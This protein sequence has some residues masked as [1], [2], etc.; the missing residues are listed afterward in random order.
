VLEHPAREVPGD[1]FHH[2]VRLASLTDQPS[3]RL[4]LLQTAR[5]M[6]DA[7][8]AAVTPN[9]VALRESLE[10]RIK[11]ELDVERR[12]ANLSRR[13]VLASSREASRARVAGVQTVLA[14]IDNEDLKLGRR[15]PDVVAALRASVNADLDAA[16]ILRL[17]RDQ[18]LLRQG[19][20]QEYQRM[21]G[22][23]L[24]GLVKARSSLE[25]IR[26]LDGPQ[27]ST[28][29]TLRSR[30]SG[31]AE[32]LERLRVPDE[33][34]ATHDLVVG[35]WRFAENATRQRAD[36]V[37]S[38]NMGRAWEASSAAAGALMMLTRAQQNI[39][40]LLELPRLP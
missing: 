14:R 5:A 9:A 33:M 8:G 1:G 18:W 25:S 24:M 34:R 23:Q 20:Y 17:R 31:G 28:L 27:L 2:V 36:A 22:S 11:G 35:A 16:R 40:E 29:Q 4:T 12:Y 32:R 7:A 10:I 6:L 26:R 38:G 21:V 13:I 39:R 30:L 15:R 3:E 19:V 37:A